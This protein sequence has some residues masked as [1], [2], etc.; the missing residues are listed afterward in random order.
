MKKITITRQVIKNGDSICII[1]PQTEAK[2]CGIDAG[3]Y[4]EAEIRKVMPE[5]N[6]ENE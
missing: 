5:S 1:I 2:V 6:E 4:V 3:D